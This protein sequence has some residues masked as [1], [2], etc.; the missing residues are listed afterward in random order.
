[1][2]QLAQLPASAAPAPLP[3][4]PVSVPATPVL[5]VPA[6][7]QAV[8]ASAAA[9][10]VASSPPV[11]SVRSAVRAKPTAS[12]A[13]VVVPLLSDLPESVRAAVPKVSI[14]GSVYSEQA[15]Q[16]LLLVNNLVVGE[17]AE[18]SKELRLERIGQRSS[19]FSFRGSRFRI[20][21]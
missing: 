2:P 3:V 12:A 5:P 9:A 18:V 20:A 7:A 21:H 6:L 19:E 8:P 17:G 11:P 16:R 14:T 15:T 13:P 4:A 10:V 1:M